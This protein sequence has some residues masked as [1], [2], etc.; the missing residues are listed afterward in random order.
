MA[1]ASPAE[2]VHG[3]VAHAPDIRIYSHSPLLYWWPVWV[4]GFLL[5]LWTWADHFPPP[6]ATDG[7]AD[8]PTVHIARSP[9]P[10]AI[11][12]V[13]LLFTIVF[14]NVSLRGPWSLFFGAT[15][16][17]LVF[18]LNWLRANRDVYELPNV[19]RIA[20]RLRVIE[21]RLKTRDVE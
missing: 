5:A 19:V 8:Q 10:G 11:F 12:V 14:S 21:E 6:L 20:S 9:L 1:T 15:I 2:L 7:L 18:L 17:S 16:V 3:H 4:A 13:T